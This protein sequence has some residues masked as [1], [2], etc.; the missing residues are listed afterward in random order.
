M[1]GSHPAA[2]AEAQERS[3]PAS[4]LRGTALASTREPSTCFT[5]RGELPQ[6]DF[7]L[8]GEISREVL[9][10]LEAAPA[11]VIAT[12]HLPREEVLERFLDSD[13][14]VFPSHREGSPNAVLEA[15]AAGLPVVSTRVGGLP[16]L[17]DEGRGGY[18]V[19]PAAVE[20]LTEA[21]GRLVADRECARRMGRHNRRICLEKFSFSV[22]FESLSTIYDEIVSAK[23]DGATSNRPGSTDS[24]ET[25]LARRRGASDENAV[26]LG[27]APRTEDRQ[28]A[29]S[30]LLGTRAVQ[31][32][33]HC[34]DALYDLQQYLRF[35]TPLRARTKERR[36]LEALLFV[37][38]HKIE[39]TLALPEPP[40]L[41]G[42][43]YLGPLLDLLDAWEHSV[44]DF[45]PSP[46]AR[47]SARFAATASAW[48]N[49]SRR[50]FPSCRRASI[51]GSHAIR[52]RPA[53]VRTAGPSGSPR[54]HFRPSAAAMDFERFALLRHSVRNFSAESVPGELIA[55]AVRTAQRTPSVCNRQAWRVHVYTSPEDKDVVLRTQDGNAGF[56]HLAASILLV[57]S[58]TRVY[59]S[60]GERHQAYVDGGMF[61]MSLVYALQ[62]QGV[63]SCCLNL[64]NYFFQDVA[65]HRA[66]RIPAWETPIMMIAIGYPAAEFQVAVSARLDTESVLSWRTL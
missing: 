22:V 23:A 49:A 63:V 47:L 28:A 38:F 52:R 41:F 13:L 31:S 40:P 9:R 30:R 51:A 14:L 16:E 59:V 64:C 58:D 17:I 39:K 61:A 32:L 50:N 6:V 2:E 24:L 29:L 1:A 46:C 15:M 62:A 21:V 45:E 10:A 36:K 56:G 5:R 26:S 27:R 44:G 35:F 19:S 7:V 12:G 20:E 8:M 48:D 33:L 43:S 25:A 65:V 60:S 55:R 37:H 54:A 3:A 18:L 66:C 57:S 42:T 4:R 34:V 11:N 53:G